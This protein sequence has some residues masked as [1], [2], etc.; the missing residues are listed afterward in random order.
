MDTNKLI[1]LAF[2]I[3]L[4]PSIVSANRGVI[5]PREVSIEESGQNAIV[6]WNGKEEVIILSI[7][8]K[9]SK[10]AQ[11]LEILPLPSQPSK[12][13]G[14]SFDSFK[15]LAEI[16]NKKI[17]AIRERTYKGIAKTGVEITFH[18]KIDVHDIT[19]IKINDLDYFIS[20]MK[21]FTLSKG[22]RNIE[23]NTLF[24]DTIANY[25]E[26][27]IKFFVLD[28][29]KTS[30]NRKSV[31]PLVYRFE[32]NFLYYPLKI[33]AASD[34]GWSISKVNV[35]LITKGVINEDTVRKINL[36]PGIGFK[37]KALFQYYIKLSKKELKEI[38]SEIADLFTS[39]YVMSTHYYGPLEKLNKDLIV[40]KQSIY[41]P[42]FFDTISQKILI[43][44]Y[45]SPIWKMIFRTST[46]I[47]LK[48]FW[49]I[50]LFSFMVGIP[51]LIVVISKLIKKLLKNYKL[52]SLSYS[53][54]AYIVSTTITIYLLLSN[55]I[56]LAIS[57]FTIAGFLTLLFLT[58][59]LLI[60]SIRSLRGKSE[61]Y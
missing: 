47:G 24:K 4:I 56:W 19:I 14:G 50:I 27:G 11:V 57:I 12:V 54:L 7:D 44:Q 52:K 3:L 43:F 49:S 38:N 2:F 59:K 22:L 25:L 10:D 31:K 28:I 21:N 1:I 20:W 51:S 40:Y 8:I 23:I 39:A 9:S 18:K 30:K 48:V 15:K 5:G 41:I 35:F 17:G 36:Q 55:V 60:K 26:S 29:I 53:S 34:V 33:T 46:P 45:I 42:T 13:E 58:L 32:A 16:V 61:T 37:S 6:A